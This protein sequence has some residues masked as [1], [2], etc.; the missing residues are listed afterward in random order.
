VI[1]LKFVIL[2]GAAIVITYPMHQITYL[3]HCKNTLP[4]QDYYNPYINHISFKREV[5]I[6]QDRRVSDEGGNGEDSNKV[7]C[8]VH[9]C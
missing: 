8:C 6:H 1:C 3:Y 9:T 5:V 7:T 4:C 2:L